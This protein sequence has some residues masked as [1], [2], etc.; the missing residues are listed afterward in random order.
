MLVLPRHSVAPLL[1]ALLSF[2]NFLHAGPH[3]PAPSGFCAAVNAT[4]SKATPPHDALMSRSECADIEAL[5]RLLSRAPNVPHAPSKRIEL[6]PPPPQAQSERVTYE[7]NVFFN[8][9]DN[10]LTAANAELLDELSRKLSATWRIESF[11]LVGTQDPMEA[12]AP[13]LQVALKR[14]EGLQRQLVAAGVPANVPFELSI[15]PPTHSNNHEGRARD[16]VVRVTVTALRRQGSLPIPSAVSRVD[17]EK[18]REERNRRIEQLEVELDRLTTPASESPQG[19]RSS[20]AIRKQAHAIWALQEELSL[21]RAVDTR[22]R[23]IYSATKDPTLKAY[24]AAIFDRIEAAGTQNFPNDNG[25]PVYGKVFAQFTVLFDGTIG[26]VDVLESDSREL[27]DHTE[28]LLRSVA[29]F[30]PFPAAL[31]TEIDQLVISAPFDYK[32]VAP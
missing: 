13:D 7:L 1:V 28:A 31:A 27:S 14:A 17:H 29:P 20:V 23:T 10:R 22:V 8:L 30:E 16:R 25:Q 18:A 19:E 24:R 4:L 12:S 26:F 5:A 32:H 9:F 11:K 2:P 21:L 3:D 15:A 6:Q